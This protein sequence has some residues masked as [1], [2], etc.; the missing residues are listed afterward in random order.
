MSNDPYGEL[1]RL[2]DEICRIMNEDN[3]KICKLMEE[4]AALRKE[5]ERL[6]EHLENLVRPQRNMRV[7]LLRK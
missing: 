3:Q 1:N 4:N 5:N 2:N 7:K 6:K